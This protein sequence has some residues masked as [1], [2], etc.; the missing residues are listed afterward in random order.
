[1]ISIHFVDGRLLIAGDGK[2]P[3]REEIVSAEPCTK[4]NRGQIK[5]RG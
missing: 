4:I 3:G 5:S 2:A 1:M